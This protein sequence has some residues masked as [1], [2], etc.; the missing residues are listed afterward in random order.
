MRTVPMGGA[1]NGAGAVC[2][3]GSPASGTAPATTAAPPSFR[4]SRRFKSSMGSPP[5]APSYSVRDATWGPG[6]QGP[7][8]RA[9]RHGQ[10]TKIG[11]LTPAFSPRTR[12][13]FASHPPRNAGSPI[14]DP[15][16]LVF[17]D[18]PEQRLGVHEVE[19]LAALGEPG[20]ERAEQGGCLAGAAMID[21][22]VGVGAGGP[23]LQPAC[24]LRPRGVERRGE[25]RLGLGVAARLTRA[26]RSLQAEPFGL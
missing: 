8:S 1:L 6:D 25:R 24:A 4:K 17:L 3:A 13:D 14:P 26:E 18:A 16:S 21:Q 9:G 23:E 5:A 7:G 20:E 19:H 22:E 12:A 15:V 11:L 10:P 2:A